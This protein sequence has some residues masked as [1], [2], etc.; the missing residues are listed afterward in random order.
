MI[1][2]IKSKVKSIIRK[3]IWRYRADSLSYVKWL[4]KQGCEI[5]EGVNFI[6][7]RNG[8]VDVSRPWM[9]RI[10]NNVTI[11]SGVVI[12][13]HDYGWSVMKVAYGDIIGNARPAM[14]GDNVFIGMN[15]MVLGGG[16]IG[17]NVIIG[18]N[19]TVSG[20]I[21][22]NCVAAGNPAKVICSLADYKEKRESRICNEA[23]VMVK[24]Y[25]EK[26]GK[27]PP[28]DILFEHFW[29]YENKIQHLNPVCKEALGWG[30]GSKEKTLE[31]FIH[32]N[33]TYKNYGEFLE[34]CELENTNSSRV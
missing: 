25:Y 11:T 2:R 9:V 21:P 17:N 10:G 8:W 3:L 27:I 7:P 1:D 30:R 13:T 16:K 34:A 24:M 32:H 22:D 18:A 5:G 6:D 33:P 29:I 19:S 31:R 12:L 23:K 28:E 4:K 20:E 26:Y 15:T 14:I